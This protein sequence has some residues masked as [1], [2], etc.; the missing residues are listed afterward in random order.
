VPELVCV[1]LL[2]PEPVIV[3][4]VDRVGVIVDDPEKDWV[5]EAEYV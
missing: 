1:I 4:V 3:E 5:I 2:V